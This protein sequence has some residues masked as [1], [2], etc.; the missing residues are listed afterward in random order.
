MRYQM[1]GCGLIAVTCAAVT[2][3]ASVSQD[4]KAAEILAATRKAIGNNRLDSLKTLSVQA[5]MQRNV[6]NF[7]SQT[8]VEMLLE[9]PDKY[10]RSDVS[11]GMMN[12]TITTGFNGAKAIMPAGA[13]ALPGGGM[14]ITMGGPGAAA[15]NAGAEAE[16]PTPEQLDQMNK[17]S[18][19]NY[20]QEI[21]RLMLGWFGMVHPSMRAQYTYVG[22]AES[23]DGKA[24]VI[25]AKDEDG[26]TA[27]LF[28][29][30]NS[31]LP[32]MVTYM[33]RQRQVM[34]SGVSVQPGGARVTTSNGAVASGGGTS[35]RQ[36]T[37]EEAK[38]LKEQTEKNVADLKTLTS[39]SAPMVQYSLF[40]EDWREVD[41]INFPHVIRRGSNG[42]TDE[43]WTISKV[44]FNGKIDA[45]KFDVTS[46]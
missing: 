6:G 13:R 17:A 24:Y 18:L 45:R 7:Q 8:E 9:M 2:T 31:K 43:E 11:S 28:I 23:P 22:E 5:S 39:Q 38:K 27:R 14:V 3:A 12:M 1:I 46:R 4:G 15:H 26:F 44:K 19:R 34:T 41:G 33:G 36:L 35:T 30:Q 16:K 37:E 29:D 21:S 40:F 42:T 25:E 32:L 20:R 10:V